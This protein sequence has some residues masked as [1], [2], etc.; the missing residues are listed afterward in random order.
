MR[1]FLQVA[2]AFWAFHEVLPALRGLTIGI[3]LR[4]HVFDQ[5]RVLFREVLLLVP[6]R[7]LVSVIFPHGCF[8]SLDEGKALV[9][10]SSGGDTRQH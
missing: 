2:A 8:R 7:L 9:Q 6:V 1:A 3:E 4:S 5:V 10:D